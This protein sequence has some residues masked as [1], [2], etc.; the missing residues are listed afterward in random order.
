M[1]DERRE[2]GERGMARDRGGCGRNS[3][4]I[5]PFLSRTCAVSRCLHGLHTA[6]ASIHLH[7][8][9]SPP[10]LTY[11]RTIF[12]HETLSSPSLNWVS[13]GAV[14]ASE[15]K[16]VAKVRIQWQ[17]VKVKVT[18]NG[19][20]PRLPSLASVRVR[21]PSVLL[22]EQQF[23]GNRVPFPSAPILAIY[24][25]SEQRIRSATR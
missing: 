7:I 16:E 3:S 24:G 11:F 6:L 2:R 12:H 21:L 9:T 14:T 13:I 8:P 5:T 15:I 22:R 17:N 23:V 18:A 19:I 25:R 10:G 1:D 4:F 20:G